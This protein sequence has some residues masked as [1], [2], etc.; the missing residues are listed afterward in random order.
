LAV[1]WG[2]WRG[3]ILICGECERR[4]KG[5]FGR[6][7]METNVL[8]GIRRDRQGRAVDKRLEEED[9]AGVGLGELDKLCGGV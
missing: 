7:L 3:S 6:R 1:L 4:G 5:Q 2:R 8:W 9:K